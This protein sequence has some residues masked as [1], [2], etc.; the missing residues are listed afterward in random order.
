PPAAPA[1]AAP[2]PTEKGSF[3]SDGFGDVLVGAGLAAA[4]AGGVLLATAGSPDGAQTYDDFQMRHDTAVTH[5]KFGVIAL[6]VGA[7]LVVGGITHWVIWSSGDETGVAVA[8]R[9]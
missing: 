7:A 3:L 2:S 1:P 4:I 6:G 5:Q 8:G 9:F